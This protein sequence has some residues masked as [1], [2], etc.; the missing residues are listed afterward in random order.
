[1]VS[2]QWHHACEAACKIEALCKYEWLLLLL[3][4]SATIWDGP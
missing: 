1:M 3:L 4:K 2:I